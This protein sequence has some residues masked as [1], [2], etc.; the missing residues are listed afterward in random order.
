MSN[1]LA[2]SIESWNVFGRELKSIRVCLRRN[3]RVVVVKVREWPQQYDS[4]AYGAWFP[5]FSTSRISMS[6]SENARRS[7]RR[8]AGVCS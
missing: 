6:E 7:N 8:A 5:S 1:L 2:I 3:D 4:V